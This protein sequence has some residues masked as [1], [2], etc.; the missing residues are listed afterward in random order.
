[1]V[2]C[3]TRTKT[4][5]FT[6]GEHDHGNEKDQS[7]VFKKYIKNHMDEAIGKCRKIGA[8]ALRAELMDAYGDTCLDIP[9]RTQVPSPPT[10]LPICTWP[11]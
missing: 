11:C 9:S 5:V 6:A 2:Q 3:P 1:M 4:E 8:K 10:L 7:V